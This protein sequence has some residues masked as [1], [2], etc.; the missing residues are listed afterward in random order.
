MS[1]ET[2]SEKVL[3]IVVQKPPN[4]NTEHPLKVLEPLV[5]SQFPLVT[6]QELRADNR[7]EMYNLLAVDIRQVASRLR[8]AGKTKFAKYWE[9]YLAQHP[10]SF[11]VLEI[12]EVQLVY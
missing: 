4:H 2:I 1:S 3:E 12:D 9:Q 11:L 8:Q 5:G 7:S 6:K 10:G